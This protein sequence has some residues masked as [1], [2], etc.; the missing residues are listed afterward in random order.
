MEGI[1]RIE[2][3]K[4]IMNERR[5]GYW[6]ASSCLDADY[7]DSVDSYIVTIGESFSYDINDIDFH[8]YH[9]LICM[10]AS[11][12]T[13]ICSLEWCVIHHTEDLPFPYYTYHKA[14]NNKCLSGKDVYD[15]L[16]YLPKD[17]HVRVLKMYDVIRKEVIPHIKITKLIEEDKYME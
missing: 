14:Y 16:L 4:R 5:V 13:T 8:L 7:F 10:I 12:H 15:E 9:K 2:K 11:Y 3:V 6:S 1:P 17:S